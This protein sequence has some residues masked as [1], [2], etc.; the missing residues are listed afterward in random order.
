MAEPSSGAAGSRST[1]PPPRRR[2]WPWALGLVVV[3]VAGVAFAVQTSGAAAD[4]TPATTYVTEAAQAGDLPEEVQADAAVAYGD[5]AVFVLRSDAQGI[6]TGVHLQEREPPESLEPALEINGV[7]VFTL[8]SDIPLYRDLANGSE[9]EDVEALESA[10]D[11]AGYDPGEVDD[12]F[13][14]DT[15][16]AVSEW[17][18]DQ[19]VEATGTLERDDVLWVPPGAAVTEVTVRP[20]DPVDVGTDVATVADLDNLVLTVAVEQADIA[21]IEQD[22]HVAVELDGFDADVDGTVSE[23]PLEPS[24]DGTYPVTV[25]PEDPAGLRV[26]MT[27]TAAVEVDV[28][29]DAV[30][31]PTGAVAG[32]HGSPVVR[33]LVDGQPDIR[34][35]DIGLVTAAG[36]EIT[37]GVEAGEPVI[38]SETGNED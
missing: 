3:A 38:I 32:E 5:A 4:R 6:V 10:L 18:E 9:G 19:D 27:G 29:T 14:A 26:G 1:L 28:R 34:H 22:Q 23:V 31:V 37:S 7:P 11:G 25:T 35:V 12:V 16:A 20:G 33:V 8:A 24:D 36:T 15:A 2:R 21:R 17:Q 13:D 30:I